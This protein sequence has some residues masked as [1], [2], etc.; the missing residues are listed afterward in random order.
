M[1]GRGLVLLDALADRW[2]VA[3]GPCPRNTVW[4]ECT[5]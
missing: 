5:L 4:A 2:G 1:K 3:A